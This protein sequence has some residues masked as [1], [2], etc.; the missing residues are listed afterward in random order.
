MENDRKSPRCSVHWRSAILFEEYGRRETLQCK[1]NDISSS[2]VSLICQR[3]L[4]LRHGVT[5]YLLIDPGD[6]KRPQLIVE[7]QGE[8]MNSVLSGQQGGFRL[9]IQ[10]TKF[11]GDSKQ[12]LLKHLP[13]DLAPAVK[14]AAAVAVTQ[15]EDLTPTE[16]VASTGDV[17]PA[18][19]ETPAE[20]VATTADEV[21]AEP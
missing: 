9:G 21:P 3:N 12:L 11:A 5:V 18:A 6:G 14:R 20:E 1:T 7:S 10:F 13:K 16:D 8:I 15:A 2:G 17:V 4:P 19:D